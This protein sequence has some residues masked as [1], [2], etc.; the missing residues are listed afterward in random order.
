MTYDNEYV[1]VVSTLVGD[2]LSGR[3][4][5]FVYLKKDNL[6]V[7]YCRHIIFGN[8]VWSRSQSQG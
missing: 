4:V 2:L 1:V 8:D 7:F 3:S 6:H 5:M